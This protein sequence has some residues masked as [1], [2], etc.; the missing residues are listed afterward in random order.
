MLDVSKV[1][2]TTSAHYAKVTQ[3]TLDLRILLAQLNELP[4]VQLGGLIQIGVAHARGVGSQVLNSL[5]PRLFCCQGHLQVGGRSLPC[6]KRDNRLLRRS[7]PQQCQ[8]RYA[9]RDAF[10]LHESVAS[11]SRPEVH[12]PSNRNR[13]MS[14]TLHCRLAM[15][16]TQ[17]KERAQFTHEERTLARFGALLQ[18]LSPCCHAV[19]LSEPSF[20]I[21]LRP[22][23]QSSQKSRNRWGASSV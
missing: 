18:S 23:N 9:P 10:H 1:S 4:R 8:A 16:D 2:P 17:A 21:I 12:R 5:H 19:A 3:S 6:N 7:P 14:V 15:S 11:Q 20:Q 22:H 13:L